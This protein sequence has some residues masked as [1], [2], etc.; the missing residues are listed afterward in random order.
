MSRTAKV[1]VVVGKGEDAKTIPAGQP[2]KG[3][4]AEDLDRL[5]RLG[6]LGPEAPPPETETQIEG[7]ASKPDATGLGAIAASR[8]A[9]A[10]EGDGTLTQAEREAAD[11]A[12]AKKAAA[13]ET[14][15]RIEAEKKAGKR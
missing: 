3:V 5:Q 4:S 10:K 12:E 8:Q 1:D 13:E 9:A 2:L 7:D 14:A 6:A 15:R 11:A